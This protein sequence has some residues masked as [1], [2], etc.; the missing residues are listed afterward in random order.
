MFDVFLLLLVSPK[1]NCTSCIAWSARITVSLKGL[2]EV[3]RWLS[4]SQSHVSAKRI[5]HDFA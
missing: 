2:G 5:R 3:S 4:R 1:L